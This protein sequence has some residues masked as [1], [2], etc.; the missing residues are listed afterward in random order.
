VIGARGH[1][2]IKQ[3]ILGSISNTVVHNSKIPVLIVK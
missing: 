2:G 1:G 3:M